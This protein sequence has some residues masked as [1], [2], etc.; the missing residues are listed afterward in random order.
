MDDSGIGLGPL[1]GWGLT[2]LSIVGGVILRDR[3]VMQ[4]ISDGDDKLHSRVDKVKD[5]Y[6]RRDD[7]ASHIARIEKSVDEVKDGMREQRSE[8][9]HTNERL[10][11]TLTSHTSMLQTM[12][13]LLRDQNRTPPPGV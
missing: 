13:A 5:E 8:Q 6:V 3:Q 11:A 12:V 10:D 1:V 4:S 9:Q 2:V 7:L